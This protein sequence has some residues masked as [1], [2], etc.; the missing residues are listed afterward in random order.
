MA[1]QFDPERARDLAVSM[2]GHASS[3]EDQTYGSVALEAVDSD[4][5]GAVVRLNNAADGVDGLLAASTRATADEITRVADAVL[6]A[7]MEKPV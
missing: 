6:Y 3:I 2:R 5:W 1:V 7:D 4:L